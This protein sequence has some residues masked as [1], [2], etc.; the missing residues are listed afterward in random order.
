MLRSVS[1]RAIVGHI[2]AHDVENKILVLGCD[3]CQR[4]EVV[5]HPRVNY[6]TVQR[7]L[8]KEGVTFNFFGLSE[9]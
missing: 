6:E 7:I 9:A 5:W 8:C 3:L 2:G 4:G 1:N